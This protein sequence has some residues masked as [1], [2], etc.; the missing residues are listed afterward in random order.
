M[1][2]KA[3]QEKRYRHRHLEP[4][5]RPTFRIPSRSLSRRRSTKKS[6]KMSRFFSRARVGG[7][8]DTISLLTDVSSLHDTLSKIKKSTPPTLPPGTKKEK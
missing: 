1:N 7:G 5:Q 4:S 2:L 3:I 8:K 6:T